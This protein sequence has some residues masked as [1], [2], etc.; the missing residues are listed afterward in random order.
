MNSH[1]IKFQSEH[2]LR[3][4]HYYYF[5][6]YSSPVSLSMLA[7]ALNGFL[8]LSPS[9]HSQNIE[10]GRR[11]LL[12]EQCPDLQEFSDEQLHLNIFNISSGTNR[13][14]SLTVNGPTYFVPPLAQL[15]R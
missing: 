2:L 12:H 7:F 5:L 10:H 8:Q 6:T 9:S 13:I 3:I 11:D 1:N 15:W 4:I 14:S